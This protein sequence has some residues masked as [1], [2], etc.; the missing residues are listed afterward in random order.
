MA[1][2]LRRGRGLLKGAAAPSVARL[3]STSTVQSTMEAMPKVLAGVPSTSPHAVVDC[4]SIN[5]G[6]QVVVE[7]ADN[8][9]YEIHASWLKD[10]NP[11]R[12]GADY[13]RTCAEDV[14][15]VKN[16]RISGAEPRSGGEQLSVDYEHVET[17]PTRQEVFQSRWLHS[18]APFVGKALNPGAA[19]VPAIRETG[20]LM[21]HL[22]DSRKPWDSKGLD[23][24]KFDSKLLEAD[25]DAQAEFY[26][27]MSRTGVAMITGIGRP[28][29][30][31][32][33]LGGLPME[34]H[35]K[36]ILGKC[37]QHPM[38]TTR[39]SYIRATEKPQSGDYDHSNPLCM[40]TD[41]TVYHGTPGFFMFLYQAEGDVRSKV[42]DGLAIAE[43]MK[44]H[45]REAYELLT[46]VHITHSSRNNLYTREGNAIDPT[47][48]NSKGD[49]FELCHT[50]P[51]LGL[52]EKGRLDKVVQSETKRGV[53]ALPYSVYEPFM[54]AY[55]LWSQLVE[56][57]RF[58]HHFDW[59]EGTMVVTNNWR[60]L[61]GRAAVPPGMSRAV[62][63]G[64]VN[65]NT[66]ENRY[67]LLKQYQAE[68]AD[69]SM[70]HRWLT[71]LPNQALERMVL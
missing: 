10:S 5:G 66:V 15:S 38:R 12:A 28:D 16:F 19:H 35:V 59:P 13:Y 4:K 14:W 71:R 3:T 70:D 63:I 68:R 69:P 49:A 64:Y 1:A 34:N 37:N 7:F 20:S 57:P 36:K 27:T 29:S 61:H 62:A 25:V 11:T 9:R 21:D 18:M 50:H 43:Y 42:C 33:E 45:H 32:F 30:L 22:M 47:D 53:T 54:E 41:H 46:K 44:E 23:M 39:Y 26:D 40:H 24:P 65:K 48:P 67:R 31:D 55:V 8:T 60:V 6:K 2:F 58:V 51:I 52:D 17:G 56:D